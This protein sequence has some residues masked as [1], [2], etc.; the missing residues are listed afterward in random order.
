MSV[1]LDG[2]TVGV[3][4]VERDK[5]LASLVDGSI[6]S[7]SEE[8]LRGITN[9]RNYAFYYCSELTS[10]T[11]PEGVASIG[12]AAFEGCSNNSLT[13]VTIPTSVTYVGDHAFRNCRGLTS[14][15]Y[16]GQ[17][18]DIQYYTFYSSTSIRKYDFRN[19]TTVPS[20][21]S[22]PSYFGHASG[23]FIIVPDELYDEWITA[24]NW[25]SLT[26]VNFIKASLADTEV[27]VQN[28]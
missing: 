9:I 25:V 20:L 7:I 24:T 22:S 13:S 19:C 28:E 15:I 27:E 23:C 16:E 3:T 18:P 8:D 11:I 12:Y 6:T 17:A 21:S 1:Y 2:E 4:I 5:K 10:I 26:D 14:V